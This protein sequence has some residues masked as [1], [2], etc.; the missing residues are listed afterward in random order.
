MICTVTQ[1]NM[2]IMSI[3][4]RIWLLEGALLAALTLMCGALFGTF[5]SYQKLVEENR[6]AIGL[7]IDAQQVVLALKDAE[8]SRT[9]YFEKRDANSLAAYKDARG[10]LLTAISR[11]QSYTPVGLDQSD[12]GRTMGMIAAARLSRMDSDVAITQASRPTPRLNE[13]A[14]KVNAVD[15]AQTETSINNLI[16]AHQIHID[17]IWTRLDRAR[18][19]VVNFIVMAGAFIV[20]TSLAFIAI[21]ARYL[22]R[23]LLALATGLDTISRNEN[24][25]DVEVPAGDELGLVAG[26]FNRLASHLRDVEARRATVEEELKQANRELVAR[27]AEVTARTRS[28]D[29]LG[30]VA[31]R[32]PGCSNIHEFASL[33]ESFVP[34]LF[35]NIPGALYVFSQSHTVLTE[36]AQWG[37]PKGDSPEFNPQ[38]CWGLRRGQAHEI[39]NVSSDVVCDHIK[40]DAILGYRCLPLVAQSETVGLLYLERTN[41][42]VPWAIEPHDLRVLAETLALALVNLKLRESLREQSIRDP[43]TGLFNRRFLQ[44]A[45]ELLQA[46]VERSDLTIGAIMIDIDHFKD[47]NDEYGHDA[48]DAALKYLSDLM[49]RHVRASDLVCRFGGE[50]FLIVMPGAT[51]ERATKCAED[52]RKGAEEMQIVHNGIA[53]KK[54]TISLGVALIPDHAA[55]V[56]TLLEAADQALYVAKNGGRNRIEIATPVHVKPHATNLLELPSADAETTD[57]LGTS[58]LFGS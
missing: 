18:L 35:P 9:A 52:L 36:V 24:P 44:E 14:I 6:N 13:I 31:Y 37:A 56:K 53:L 39:A 55:D 50:E 8:T 16:V 26:A 58:A 12:E 27:N 32:L 21:S 17:G 4:R 41:E 42:T 7:M 33:V 49:P 57:G 20:V 47:F 45:L 19:W 25:K 40:R 46:R 28:I 51:M 1:S 23:P 34:Q 29:L 22:A 43:L 48:G 38:N 54:F 5:L 11:I 2:C 30:R 3:R 10:N 15:K